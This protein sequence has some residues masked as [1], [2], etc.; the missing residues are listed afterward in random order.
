[1]RFGPGRNWFWAR[2][3]GGLTGDSRKQEE[4]NG[5]AIQVQEKFP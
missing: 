2:S 3:G 5:K 4:G 1:M